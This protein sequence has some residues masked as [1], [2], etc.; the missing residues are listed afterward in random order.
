MRC[1]V[2][3]KR[4]EP[5]LGFWMDIPKS[6]PLQNGESWRSGGAST[7][8]CGRSCARTTEAT[9]AKL[10]LGLFGQVAGR[11]QVLVQARLCSLDIRMSWI[12]H[13]GTR[14]VEHQQCFRLRNVSSH[15]LPAAP[16]LVVLISCQERRSQ[17]L[18]QSTQLHADAL[19]SWICL[20]GDSQQHDFDQGPT[21]DMDTS[22]GGFLDNSHLLHFEVQHCRTAV[23]R[24]IPSWLGRSWILPG[25]A[26]PHR[27]LVPKG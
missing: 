14:S 7:P 16:G 8:S 15:L 9:M 19:D 6:I 26:V 11:A 20:R 10:H 17:S 23:R 22:L 24:E 27:L 25:Y 21:I 1:L 4:P 12:L 3:L 2:V 18:W 5:L 13:Q